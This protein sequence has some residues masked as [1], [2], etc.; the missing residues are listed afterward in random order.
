VSLA[1]GILGAQ[2]AALVAGFGFAAWS[3][4]KD[5]EVTD[6]L[7]QWLGLIGVALGAV[8][9]GGGGLLPTALWLLVGGLAL[10]H[11]FPWDDLLGERADR[12]ADGIEAVAY[13]VV[14]AAVAIAV[15]RVGVGPS[16]VPWAVVAL[17]ASILLARGLFEAGV[18]YGG[19]DAKALMIAGVLVPTFTA[20]AWPLGGTLAGVL[21]WVP[22]SLDLLTNAAL[23]SLAIPLAIGLRNVARKEFHF[24]GGFSGYRIPVRELPERYVWLENPMRSNAAD[25]ETSEEDRQLRARLAQELTAKGVETVWVT[26]QIPFLVVMAVG[27][28]LTLLA[29]NLVL[30]LVALA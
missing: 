27:A 29:G 16:E 8:A 1:E 7:W 6:R 3:D 24:P 26:P 4:L 23:V 2:L 21:G 22:F 13:A 25:V 5:R 10:E 17:L 30:D 18:L 19:A 15:V 20:V 9:F 12:L 11:M 14:V 28:V